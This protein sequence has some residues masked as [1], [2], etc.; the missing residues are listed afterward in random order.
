MA[1]GGLE[2]VLCIHADVPEE[3]KEVVLSEKWGG[4][5][6]LSHYSTYALI[7]AHT[8]THTNKTLM[9]ATDLS[10]DGISHLKM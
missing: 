4:G 6:G 7:H 2:K 8:N 1:E 5:R 3:G 9:E 10:W